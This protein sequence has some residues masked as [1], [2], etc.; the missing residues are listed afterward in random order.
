MMVDGQRSKLYREKGNALDVLDVRTR[1]F[2]Y[3][4]IFAYKLNLLYTY[5][6]LY[7]K[8]IYHDS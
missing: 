1:H 6:N 4:V 7:H 3:G 8:I 2:L 5:G